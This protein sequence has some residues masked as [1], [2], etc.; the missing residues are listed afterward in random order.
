MKLEDN[1]LE[2][3]TLRCL[4]DALTSGTRTH[5]HRRA[6]ALE[7]ARPRFGD[8]HGE[9]SRE[10]LRARYARL[11]LQ[12]EQCR[13][14]AELLDHDEVDAAL[15][16]ELLGWPALTLIG[17]AIDVDED[18]QRAEF[19]DFAASWSTSDMAVA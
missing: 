3:F 14:H 9:A 4:Q 16:A 17:A 10:S 18:A 8:F 11:T 13:V 7:D 1:Y 12:A 19:E 5:W 6:D 15:I 2:R